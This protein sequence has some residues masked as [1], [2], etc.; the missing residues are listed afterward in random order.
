MGLKSGWNSGESGGE[1]KRGDDRKEV[2]VTEVEKGRCERKW[3]WEREVVS[4][5]EQKG[6]D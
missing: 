1:V 2:K 6:M 3:E 5:V 4:V